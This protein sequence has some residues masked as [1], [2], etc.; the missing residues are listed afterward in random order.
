[1]PRRHASP[2]K[3]RHYKLK[4]LAVVRIDGKDHYLG[5]HGTAESWEAYHRLLAERAASPISPAANRNIVV[6]PRALTVA[7]LVLAYWNHAKAYYR[8]PDGS[9]SAEQE[10]IK[11]ALRPLRKCY[12]TTPAA[13]FG[14]VALKAVRQSMI[15]SGLARSTINHRIGKVV[16]VFRWGVENEL[17]PPSSHHALRAVP[18]L[19]KGRTVAPESKPVRPVPDDQVDAIRPFVSRQIWGM[20]E[21]QRLTAARP[22]EVVCMRSGDID[23]SSETW[24]YEPREHKTEHHGI[25]RRIAIGPR[26]QAVLNEFLRDDPHAYL[27]QPR[28]A[29]A[30]TLAARRAARVT[31]MTPS[32]GARKRKAK[33]LRAPGE[34]Y[35]KNAYR[36]AIWRACDRAFPHP[37]LS[38]VPRKDLTETQRAELKAWRKA[39]R[40]HPH[41]LRHAAATAIRARFGLEAAQVVLGHSKAD[42]TQ[43]YAERDLAKAV[44]VAREI[45]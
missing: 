25:R 45:G 40:W 27:Y 4:D 10:N 1:M 3:Y 44:E 16:R 30:V 18:G 6:E 7:E 23:R 24:V 15:E 21:V 12:G 38:G 34:F 28:E 36:T 2:P 22:G 39:H 9:P 20:V 37:M 33:V 43:V 14:P 13:S 11:L 17:V 26:A 29:V 32:Q 35:S 5:R 31:P 19:K 8:R 42:V 41:R